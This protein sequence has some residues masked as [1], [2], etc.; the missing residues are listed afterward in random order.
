MDKDNPTNLDNMLLNKA[1]IKEE[2]LTINKDN[3]NANHSKINNLETPEIPINYKEIRNNRIP[4]HI[5]TFH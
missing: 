2:D 3:N 1:I 4:R 5:S